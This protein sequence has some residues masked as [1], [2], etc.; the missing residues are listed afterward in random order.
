MKNY[1][2]YSQLVTF[3]IALAMVMFSCVDDEFDTP[4]IT[5]IPIGDV[6]TIQQV[7]DFF[8]LDTST[9]TFTDTA[10]VYATVTMDNETDNS[11]RTFFIQDNTGAIAVFQDVSG[12]VYIGDSVRIYLK[13]LVVMQYQNLFQ[14]NNVAGDGVNVDEMLI[15]QG[16]NN[17][18]VPEVTTIDE[19]SSDPAYWQGRLVKVTGVQFVDTDI[20]KTFANAETLETENRLI[21]DSDDDQLIV[22]TSGY[23]TFA[24]ADVP[25]GSGSIVAIVGQYGNDLQLYV[26]R[27]SE[28]VMESTRFDVNGGGTGS[29]TGTLDDPYDVASGIL[30]NTGVK[31]WVKGYIV[32]AAEYVDGTGNVFHFDSPYGSENTNIMIADN[33]NETNSANVLIVQLPSGVV[34]NILNLVDNTGNKDKEVMVRGNLENYFGQPG[35]KETI[36]CIIDDTEY[37]ETTD[38]EAILYEDFSSIANPYDPINIAGWKIVMEAG[39]KTWQGDGYNGQAAEISAYESGEASNIAWL[40]T[41]AVDLSATTS[42]YLSFYSALKYHAGDILSVHVST[43]YDGGDS[44]QTATWTELTGADI[45]T[46]S[47]P[48]D[49]DS[50]YNY[51]ESGNVDL[52]AYKSAGVYIAFKYNGSNTL[53]TKYR[54]DNIKIADL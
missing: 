36:G 5:E 45:V 52:S 22:R 18:R 42:P 20:S 6:Y 11:Y 54:V 3:V 33:V 51:T 41:P 24:D 50:G 10:S 49:G 27:L 37:G 38:V 21:Q 47:D 16:Y 28:V 35:M 14:I 43:D 1:R 23:S 7:K 19:I 29:G 53:T 4:P 26:R 31:Q 46:T 44:P 13:D 2:K 8:I 32:G 9:Y 40:I 34:R 17:K 12:G 39:T 48:V 30:N 15:K 25:N